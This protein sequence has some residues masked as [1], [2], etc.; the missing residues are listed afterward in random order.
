M[1]IGLDWRTG[2]VTITF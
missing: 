2:A 1:L